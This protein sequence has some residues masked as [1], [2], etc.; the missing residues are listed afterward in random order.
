MF[1]QDSDVH[2]SISNVNEPYGTFD[3][4]YDAQED[5]Y[6]FQFQVTG[7]DITSGGGG[8]AEVNGF[9]TSWGLDNVVLGFTFS[10]S[11][12]PAGSGVLASFSYQLSPEP[13]DICIVGT[14]VAGEPTPENFAPELSSSNGACHHID[15]GEEV[16]ISFDLGQDGEVSPEDIISRTL[17]LNYSSFVNISGF[18]FGI[19]GDYIESASGGEA[20]AANFNLSNYYN[21]AADMSTVLGLSFS[22]TTIPA[23]VGTLVSLTVNTDEEFNLC[24]NIDCVNGSDAAN[25]VLNTTLTNSDLHSAEII[26]DN[27]NCQFFPALWYDCNDTPLGEAYEDDCGDCVGGTTGNAENFNDPDGDGVCNAVAANDE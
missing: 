22:G 13:A 14:I 21:N 17:S 23:G 20:A 15:G 19:D 4:L 1:A 10:G 18:Q 24:I 16:H 25:C 5:I 8:A 12:I 11:S 9:N 2:L 3:V 26:Y 27:G 7:V 6:G